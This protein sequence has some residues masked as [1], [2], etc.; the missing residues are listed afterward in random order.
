MFRGIY[1]KRN[2][3]MYS[4][5]DIL[6][7]VFEETAV[8]AEVFRKESLEDFASSVARLFGWLIGFCNNEHIDLASA[9]FRKYHGCC[10]YCGLKANCMC[11]SSETKP[12]KWLPWKYADMPDTL[13]KWQR[14]FERIY[15]NVNKVAGRDKCW[16]HFQEE[17]GEVSRAFRL[18]ERDHL[19]DE[20]AD[21]FAWLVAFCSNCRLDLENI[22][23]NRY[24]G[25]C[26]TCHSKQCNCPKV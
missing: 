20:L 6:L 11:I 26:D 23:L 5:A 17:L 9:I 15:G 4:S 16:L 25:K 10:P 12:S 24:T 22:V 19:R 2:R 1:G 7:H 18:K 8:V 21:A 13:P 14:M 3:A